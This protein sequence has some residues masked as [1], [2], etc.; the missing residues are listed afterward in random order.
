MAS[1]DL[2]FHRGCLCPAGPESWTFRDSLP[3]WILPSGG[4]LRPHPGGQA[5]HQGASFLVT[6]GKANSGLSDQCCW[7]FCNLHWARRHG[8]LEP[9]NNY[10]HGQGQ[11]RGDRVI[12]KA[13]WIN[14][15]CPP[16]GILPAQLAA[17]SWPRDNP[18]IYF[19]FENNFY[20]MVWFQKQH[21]ISG[22]K[23]ENAGKRGKERKM[24]THPLITILDNCSV[25]IWPFSYECTMLTY[26]LQKNESYTTIT[27]PPYMA[28]YN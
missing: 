12:S 25:T 2:T 17:L 9:G 11:V 13:E 3:P 20:W 19:F 18:L 5:R 28:I 8:F 22:G 10:S 1:H 24:K 15:G 21:T 23:L 27:F 14:N 26:S 16:E 4:L 7:L 6:G